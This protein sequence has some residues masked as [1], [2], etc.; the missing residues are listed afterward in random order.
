LVI[1]AVSLVVCTSLGRLIIG[2]SES[3]VADVAWLLQ[4]VLLL[5]CIV[6]ALVAV[7]SGVRRR[8]TR[9]TMTP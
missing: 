3:G 7:T 8:S 6:T 9:R 1:F 2:D 4:M 5:A